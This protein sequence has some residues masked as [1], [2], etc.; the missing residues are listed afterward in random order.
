MRQRARGLLTFTC[1]GLLALLLAGACASGGSDRSSNA[2]ASIQIDPNPIIATQL[3]DGR[4]E[5]P[6][7]VGIRENAGVGFRIDQVSA[8]VIAFGG[9]RVHQQVMDAAEIARLGYPTEIRAN[10]LIELPFRPVRNVPDASL[11]QNVSAVVSLRG[12]D[13]NGN[14]VSASQTVRVATR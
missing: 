6:F 5:F 13:Q 1:S 9:V 14:T 7:T 8:E 4:W 2:A 12:T 3:S 10:G 11:F